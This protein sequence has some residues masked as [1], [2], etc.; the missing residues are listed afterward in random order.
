MDL[1]KDTERKLAR[2]VES[3]MSVEM[4]TAIRGPRNQRTRT[5]LA[6]LIVPTCQWA[7]MIRCSVELIGRGEVDRRTYSGANSGLFREV[8]PARHAARA[9]DGAARKGNAL[10]VRYAFLMQPHFQYRDVS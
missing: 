4:L 10:E 9:L 8:C 5:V 3:R 1:G 7:D 6:Y 2:M